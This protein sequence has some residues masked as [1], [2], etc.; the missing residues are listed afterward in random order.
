M[1][2]YHT[3]KSM[4]FINR[5][6]KSERNLVVSIIRWNPFRGIMVGSFITGQVCSCQAGGTVKC[7]QHG[8]I[9]IVQYCSFPFYSY[10]ATLWKRIR[11]LEFLSAEFPAVRSQSFPVSTY[12]ASLPTSTADTAYIGPYRKTER[13]GLRSTLHT[14]P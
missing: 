10:M 11:S 3:T 7:T 8:L 6:R 9:Q 4:I 5:Q 13:R 14:D 1:K 2:R 12:I